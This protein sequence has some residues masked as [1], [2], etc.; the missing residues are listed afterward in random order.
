MGFKSTIIVVNDVLRSRKLYESVL[1]MKVTSDFGEYNV[2]FENGLALYKKG[3]FL[4]LTGNIEIRDK[5]NS[6]VLYFEYER[7][8]EMERRLETEGLE[9]IHA[10]REQPWGQGVFRAYDYDNHILEI[11]ECMDAVFSRLFSNGKTVE[12]AAR[13]TGYPLAEVERIKNEFR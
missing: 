5:S 8:E 3:M 12:E 2:G 11:A 10:L 13:I 1:G 6:F 9:F 7:I 4:D